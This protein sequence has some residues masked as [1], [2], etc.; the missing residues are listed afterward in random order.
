[1]RLV[2]KAP[3]AGKRGMAA[4]GG[5]LKMCGHSRIYHVIENE[6]HKSELG[7]LTNG[8]MILG[9]DRSDNHTATNNVPALI[10]NYN[11]PL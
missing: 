10:K 5:E 9:N 6:N 2:I 4:E 7:I 11:N 8:K 3:G 1:M